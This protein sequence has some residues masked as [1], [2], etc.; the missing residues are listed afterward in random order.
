MATTDPSSRMGS[1]TTSSALRPVG[2]ASQVDLDAVGHSER[3]Y[4][5]V[6]LVNSCDEKLLDCRD[7]KR[8]TRYSFCLHE[9]PAWPQLQLYQSWVVHILRLLGKEIEI[10]KDDDP[11]AVTEAIVDSLQGFHFGGIEVSVS[12]LRK[13]WGYIPC[14]VLHELLKE[15]VTGRALQLPTYDPCNRKCGATHSVESIEDFA[16]S[17][18]ADLGAHSGFFSS[19]SDDGEIEARRAEDLNEPEAAPAASALNKMSRTFAQDQ[20]KGE[21]EQT[22]EFKKT[23]DEQLPSLCHAF[24]QLH[25]ELQEMLTKVETREKWI[26]Q[27]FSHIISDH[28]EVHQELVNQTKRRQKLV[29]QLE[30]L[31]T[32]QAV[33]QE[34]CDRSSKLLQ[35]KCN[36]ATDA[37]PIQELTKTLTTLR[38]EIKQMELRSGVLQHTSFRVRTPS[39]SPVQILC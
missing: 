36:R 24:K 14:K 37:R 32:K 12:S 7:L 20:W 25:E 38:K 33:T 10:R 29:V 22:L 15:L 17:H 19:D 2:S 18:E 4:N 21:V 27:K 9:E 3:I 6:S 26:E 39:T 28:G 23:F 16:E 11:V 5:L 30:D 31:Q 8:L 35:D 1:S 34:A 13:G